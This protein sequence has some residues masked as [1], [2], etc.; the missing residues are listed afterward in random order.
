MAARPAK[1][2]FGAVLCIEYAHCPCMTGMESYQF[3]SDSRLYAALEP[4]VG[5]ATLR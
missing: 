5:S 2:R 3:H 1:N 4:A